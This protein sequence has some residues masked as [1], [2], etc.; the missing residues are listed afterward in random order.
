MLY[1]YML[2]TYII[3]IKYSYLSISIHVYLSLIPLHNISF[4]LGSLAGI[5]QHILALF[6]HQV[7]DDS[8]V[9]RTFDFFTLQTIPEQI[10]KNKIFRQYLK[11]IKNVCYSNLSSPLARGLVYLVNKNGVVFNL[12]P[13]GQGIFADAGDGE[14]GCMYIYVYMYI[15]NTYNIGRLTTRQNMPANV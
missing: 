13:P 7:V 3:I 4:C 15:Y 5:F 8:M 12:L 10:F 14:G 2:Y 9:L 6:R 1:I 11:H